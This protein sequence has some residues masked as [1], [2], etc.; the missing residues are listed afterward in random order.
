MTPGPRSGYILIE[1][2]VALAILS[3]GALTINTT[4]REAIQTRGQSQDFTRARFLLD[5]VMAGITGEPVV[6]EGSRSGRFSG[7]DQRFSWEYA[8]RRVNMPPPPVPLSPDPE[9]SGE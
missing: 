5:E 8:I 3:I 2:A 4:I 6:T 9:K 1:T 7:S